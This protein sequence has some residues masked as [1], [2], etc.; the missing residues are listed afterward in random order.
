MSRCVA[1]GFAERPPSTESSRESNAIVVM[2]YASLHYHEQRI[3][4]LP[5]GADDDGD[6]RTV[7]A[8][9]TA[10]PARQVRRDAVAGHQGQ[11]LTPA[12]EQPEDHLLG[13]RVQTVADHREVTLHDAEDITRLA[14][15]GR[16]HRLPRRDRH[17]TVAGMA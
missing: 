9:R 10:A 14:R 15:T 2:E 6:L 1:S 13:H 7:L 16:R 11:Q 17:G 12:A 8:D 5:A 3:A 4:R